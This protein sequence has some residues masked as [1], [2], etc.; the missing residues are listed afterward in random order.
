LFLLRAAGG[1]NGEIQKDENAL[2][3]YKRYFEVILLLILK[4]YALESN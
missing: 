2:T 1:A 3:S 4:F